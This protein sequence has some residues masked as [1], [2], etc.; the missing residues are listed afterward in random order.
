MATGKLLHTSPTDSG[1]TIDFVFV[2]FCLCPGQSI[3]DTRLS[4][5][6][7]SQLQDSADNRTIFRRLE[8]HL[9][10]RPQ[11]ITLQGFLDLT[12]TH[13]WPRLLYSDIILKL[14]LGFTGLR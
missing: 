10:V 7:S 1:L 4:V 9:G 13:C 8:Q 12:C 14:L 6:D 11:V 3:K 5:Q 2:L